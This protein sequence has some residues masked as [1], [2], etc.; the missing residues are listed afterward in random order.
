M[1]GIEDGHQ[2]RSD[3][4][5]RG[6]DVA[7]LGKLIVGPGPVADAGLEGE[8]LK[9]LAAAV[10]EDVD[11]E[12]VGGPI[13]VERAEGG[14][15]DD[16]ERLVEGGNE[17][18][19]V[20]PVL[21]ILGQRHRSAAQRPDGLEVAEKENDECVCLGKKQ[22]EDKKCVECAPVIGG[23]LKEANDLRDAPVSVAKGTEHGQH[24][25]GESDEIGVR[26][27]RHDQRHEKAQ[28]TENRLLLQL[29]G[30]RCQKDEDGCGDD[31]K[32]KA[33]NSGEAD[34]RRR[35]YPARPRTGVIARSSVPLGRSW[36]QRRKGS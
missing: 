1:I 27:A 36:L 10:V 4:F 7:G 12:F 13:H 25:E 28:Q 24:H 19:D 2:R 22:A 35:R 31:E 14:E 18:V 23:V 34:F 3:R 26:A 17:D 8:L 21:G 15:A 6:V 33:Q 32:E 30:R 29:S 9:F 5:E 11:V 20:G 16:V